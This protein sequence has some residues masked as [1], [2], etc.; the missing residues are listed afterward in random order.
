MVVTEKIWT[1]WISFGSSYTF[2]SDLGRTKEV[3]F[4]ILFDCSSLLALLELPY[5]TWFRRSEHTRG[6]DNTKGNWL[7]CLR[8]GNSLGPRK[9]SLQHVIE[10]TALHKSVSK[11]LKE[12]IFW[13]WPLNRGWPIGG[14]TLNASVTVFGYHSRGSS[15]ITGSELA[16]A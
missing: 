7:F 12:I 10:V 2:H 1:P 8:V 3:N 5:S 9:R 4:F 6:E 16:R 13:K 15:W 11:K 14:R